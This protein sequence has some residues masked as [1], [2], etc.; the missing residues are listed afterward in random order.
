MQED[1][2]KETNEEV[3]ETDK[4][5]ADVKIEVEEKKTITLRV[6][7]AVENFGLWFLRLI[8]LKFL[9]EI[10]EK[11]IEVMRYLICGALSTIVNIVAY[12]I[13]SKFL[14]IGLE[15]ESLIVNVSEI[16]A[17]I[18]ALIFAYW[19]NKSIVFKSKCKNIKDLFREMASFTGARIF[20]ELISIGLMNLAVAIHFNDVIM[21]VIANIVV[22]ILN[23]VFS[24]LFIFKKKD[25]KK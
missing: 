16:F 3:K 14:F 13:G 2:N 5:K 22:I 25:D 15:A 9:A 17:F 10:Y 18:V 4:E 24:K 21:K 1:E 11:Q 23:Y 8:H 6:F 20:T 19:V 12:I 7:E